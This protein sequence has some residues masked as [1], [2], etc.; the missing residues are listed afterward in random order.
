[1]FHPL[2]R[3]IVVSLAAWTAEDVAGPELQGA[4]DP[5]AA[6]VESYAA[7]AHQ[8]YAEVHSLAD[9]LLVAARALVEDPTEARLVGAR[10]AWIE[11]RQAYGTTEVLRFYN[12]P[13]DRP[14]GGVETLLN[15]WPLD[16]SY[17]DAVAEGCLG[18]IV[19]SPETYPHL[20]KE[21]FAVWNE[22]G[23]EA[24]VCTGW[25]AVEF[26]LWGQDL[27]ADGPGDRPVSDF[28]VGGEPNASRR[29][30]VLLLLTEMIVDHLAMLEAEWAPDLPNYAAAFRALP[31][32]RT[33]RSMLTGMIVLSGFE[34]AGERLA[35]AYETQDPE[36]EHSCFSDTTHLDFAANQTGLIEVWGGRRDGDVGL[37]ALVEASDP[38]LAELLDR[39]L[40]ESLDRIRAIPVPFDQAL[41]DSNN[42]GRARIL[43]ALLALEAQSES[44]ATAALALGHE[45]AIRPGQ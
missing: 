20:S 41:I 11:A 27:D 7:A 12:G 16:E 21:L 43:E 44:L 40:G 45:I 35:V 30:Q 38:D 29:G 34:M 31:G 36:Q 22:R 14:Q 23:G 5:V 2:S 26:L 37:R 28:V 8:R 32:E 1:M 4:V 6:V 25:H 19:C 24:N 13:I 33:V 15:A 10:Q 17:L 9:R 3:A 39:Q 18:G 42:G